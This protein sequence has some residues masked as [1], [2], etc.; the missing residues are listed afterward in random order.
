MN[1]GSPFRPVFLVHELGK[2]TAAAL[3][4]TF[5]IKGLNP[6]NYHLHIT[7]IGYKSLTKTINL[8]SE[9]L[10]LQFRMVE[11]AITLQ[12]LTI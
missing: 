8:E 11:S 1:Q 10:E 12:S 7:H 5:I 9:D 6:G 4:G 3:D 2:G